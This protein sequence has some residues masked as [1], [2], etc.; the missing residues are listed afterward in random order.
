MGHAEFL[1]S[2]EARKIGRT[3]RR[4]KRRAV[5]RTDDALGGIDFIICSVITV[6]FF[7]GSWILGA[8]ALIFMWLP[9]FIEQNQNVIS[10]PPWTTVKGEKDCPMCHGKYFLHQGWK[11]YWLG[12]AECSCSPHREFR[13]RLKPDG[14]FEPNETKP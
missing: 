3:K 7:F 9:S 2:Q 11:T 1:L 6:V 5:K 10:V 12:W 13:K 8:L 4:K 14:R